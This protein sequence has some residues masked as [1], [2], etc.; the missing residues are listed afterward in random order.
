MAREHSNVDP[1][2]VEA[3]ILRS[4]VRKLMEKGLLSEDDVRSVLQNAVKGLRIVVPD[5]MGAKAANDIV[6]EGG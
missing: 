4:L 2:E 5:T 1:C 3:L 6:I